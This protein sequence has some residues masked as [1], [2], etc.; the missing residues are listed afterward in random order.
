PSLFSLLRFR[1][2]QLPGDVATGQVEIPA[3]RK[4]LFCDLVARGGPEC[5]FKACEI[6]EALVRRR[7]EPEQRAEC[8]AMHGAE[9]RVILHRKHQRIDLRTPAHAVRHGLACSSRGHPDL[10]KPRGRA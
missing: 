4:L 9:S 8:P 7:L 2:Y 10:T 5:N 1:L 3:N 6:A